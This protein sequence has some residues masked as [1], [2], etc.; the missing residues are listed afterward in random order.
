[1][2]TEAGTVHS[3]IRAATSDD[4]FR[5]LT[6]DMFRAQFGVEISLDPL[7]NAEPF[8]A[9]SEQVAMIAVFVVATRLMLYQALS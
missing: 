7:S 9:E 1:V 5:D 6:L 3:R 8:I 4:H 2:S